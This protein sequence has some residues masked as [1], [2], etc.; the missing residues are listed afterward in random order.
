MSA[1]HRFKKRL[2]YYRSH[3]AILDA[4]AE[5]C[6][7]E[8]CKYFGDCDFCDEKEHNPKA[9]SWGLISRGEVTEL[10]HNVCDNCLP[11]YFRNFMREMFFYGTR[12][13]DR[14]VK[15]QDRKWESQRQNYS[16]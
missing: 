11:E 15:Q 4:M 6:G 3:P 1:R 2:R 8:L 10:D 16:Q 12:E 5:K 13:F 9:R 14:M 7:L